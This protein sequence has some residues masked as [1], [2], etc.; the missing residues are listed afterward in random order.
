V[1]ADPNHALAQYQLGMTALNL[2][3]IQDA[4]TALESYLKVDPN[5]PK[6]AEV[7]ASLPALQG[8]LKK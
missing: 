5:G 1:K 2:G 3:Q 8:M 7:K 6:A 4:V